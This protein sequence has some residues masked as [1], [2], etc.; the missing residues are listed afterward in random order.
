MAQIILIWNMYS[1]PPPQKNLS[2]QILIPKTKT[3]LKCSGW[4]AVLESFFF[5]KVSLQI[6]F[7]FLVFLVLSSTELLWSLLT[8]MTAD[9]VNSVGC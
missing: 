4:V 8:G 2:S 1:S 5:Q 3:P 9:Y 7:D 6:F